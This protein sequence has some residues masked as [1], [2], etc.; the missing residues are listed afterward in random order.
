MPTLYCLRHEVCDSPDRELH[1]APDRA[2]LVTRGRRLE[3]LTLAWNGFEAAVA[4]IS[5]LLAGSVA[6][7]GFGLDSVIETVSAAILLWRFRDE[8]WTASAPSAPHADSSESASC[9]WPLTLPSSPSARSGSG[10]T[11]AQRPRHPDRR[12]C[13]D[14]DAAAR[15]RQA[16]RRRSTRQPRAPGR[17]APGGLLRLSLGHP[18]RSACCSTRCWVGGGPIPPP[19]WSWCRSSRA[20]ACRACGR[21]PATIAGLSRARDTEIRTIPVRASLAARAA[22]PPQR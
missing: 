21:R 15:P 3:Y 14:R 8:T 22:V 18:A 16:S 19:R 6:L 2:A 11:G 13:G 12:G 5:G 1:G 10:A 17:L 4:L 20:R 9:C 7:V